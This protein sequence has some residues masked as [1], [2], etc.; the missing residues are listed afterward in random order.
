MKHH[1]Q[2]LFKY[3][4]PYILLI[5]IA[6]ALLAVQ[7]VCDLALPDYMSDI[8]NQGIQ[9]S[10]IVETVPEVIRESTMDKLLIFLTAEEADKVRGQFTLADKASDAFTETQNSYI[11]LAGEP[12]YLRINDAK[13]AEDAAGSALGDALLAVSGIE[14][15]VAGAKDGYFELNGQ[16]IPA[17]TDVY[18]MLRQMPAEQVAQMMEKMTEALGDINESYIKQA[19]AAAIK[20]EYE[21]IGVDTGAMQQN[22]ILR[23]GALMLLV[24]LAGAVCTVAVGYLSARTAAG[25]A[26]DLRHRVFAKVESFSN[27]EFDR[28]S[29]A[30]LITRST[31]DITQ[32]QTVTVMAIRLAFYAPILG[33][34]GILRALEKSQSMSWLVA[35]AVILL[36]SLVTTLFSIAMPKFK[37]IQKLTDKVNLV[38]RENLSGMMV[39]RAFNTQRFEE[40][41]FDGANQELTGVSLFINR[42]M[43][44]MM[45][46]MMFLMNG[47]M[48]LIVW[49]GAHQIEQASLQVGDMMAFM[50]YTMQIIM[51]FLMVSML[52]IMVPRASVSAQRVAEVLDTKLTILDPE[53]PVQ[54]RSE[55]AGTVEFRDVCFRY[56]NAERDALSKISFTATKGRTTAIIGAT[57]SGKSTLVN[58]IPRFYDVTAGTVLVDGVDVR[59]MEQHALRAVIGYVPQKAMLFSGTL[60][61]NLSYADEHASDEKLRGAAELAQLRQF[62]EEQENGLDA[63]M[64]QGGTNVSGGQKQRLSIAR[65]LVKEPEIYIFDDSFSALDFK[66]DSLIRKALKKDLG[67]ATQIIIAQRISTIMNADQILVLDAGE[68]VG[69]GT[70]A[71][72]METCEIY[73]EIALSQLS[74]EELA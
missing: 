15:A 11:S 58:L 7:A 52:F 68:L 34:G 16:K 48:L 71:E 61:S 62:M 31:N 60:R 39:I 67:Q 40:K 12:V 30:S 49:V 13:T 20:A 9:Q 28:F 70:H 51:S 27:Q 43:S 73:R 45:P 10:G 33:V 4:K 38:I 36:L 50:Q 47:I 72:L 69:R 64:A 65:A 74:K 54:P 42:A 46:I 23:I 53:K 1:M 6:V 59:Q 35:L 66:T 2:R 29:T 44:C 18:A 3:L 5:V 8:V 17:G 22:Y 25:F 26:R 24:T 55:L 14:R 19:A 56:P 63:S 57:G 37:R 41:R 21:A 32:I